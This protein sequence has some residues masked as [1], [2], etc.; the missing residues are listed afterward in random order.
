VGDVRRARRARVLGRFVVIADDR[1]VSARIQ[2]LA[3]RDAHAEAR[4]ELCRRSLGRFTRAGWDQIEPPDT[5]LHNWHIDA[6]CEALTALFRR[7]IKRLI[8][9]VPP[10]CMKSTIASVLFPAWI[11]LQDP[12]FRMITTSYE[13]A[14]AV[15]DSIKSRRVIDGPWYTSLNIKDPETREPIFHMRDQNVKHLRRLKDSEDWYENDKHGQRLAVGVD[16]GSTGKGGHLIACDDP[17]N[18]KKAHSEAERISTLTW[19]DQTMS[20]RLDNQR[21]GLKLI[22]MQRLHTFDLTGHELAKNI[23]YTHIRFP[24]EFDPRKRCVVSLGIDAKTGV[25]K[26]WAD[27]RTQDKEL[28]WTA[29]FPADIIPGMK[30]DLTPYGWAGQAQQEPVPEGGAIFKVDWFKSFATHP[31]FDVIAMSVDC[32]FT[33]AA[34][35]SYVVI[36]VWGFCGPNAYLLENIREHL[37]FVQTEAAI[38]ATYERYQKMQLTPNAILVENKAN[39]P[40][41]IS[42][43]VTRFPGIIPCEPRKMGGSKEA[44]ASSVSPFVMAGN[45]LLPHDAHWLADFYLEVTNFPRYSS[46][47]QVDAMSQALWWRY[48]SNIDVKN[49]QA[50]ARFLQ[51][52]G[53]ETESS[54]E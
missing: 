14:L 25:E 44:R 47:D 35:S 42:R 28:L 19:W 12:T 53:L 27:P 23:G 31:L 18:P 40:A 21:T 10:R 37:S 6:I 1:V 54:E 46:D 11:W 22:V 29:R 52:A 17:Q 49:V 34:T 39:G 30:I 9:N 5:Y 26:T 41:V 8:L 20:T 15:R 33:D 2:Q 16:G 51:W 3:T 13:R 38:S 48:L 36:Q 24:M 4:A 7:Q 32:A 50:K 43:L 45:V